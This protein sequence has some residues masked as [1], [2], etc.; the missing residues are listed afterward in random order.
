MVRGEGVVTELGA[1]CPRDVPSG[2]RSR[3]ERTGPSMKRPAHALRHGRP[4]PSRILS[5]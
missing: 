1:P 3:R 2:C 4:V 5:R